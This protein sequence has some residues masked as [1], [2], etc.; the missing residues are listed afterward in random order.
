MNQNSDTKTFL[1]RK[2]FE[3]TELLTMVECETVLTEDR[4]CLHSTLNLTKLKLVYKIQN[5][6]GSPPKVTSQLTKANLT[7]H[8]NI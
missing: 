7:G 6:I 3:Q 8:D 5:W 1:T 2:S 4:Y